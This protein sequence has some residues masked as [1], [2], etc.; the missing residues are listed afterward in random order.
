MELYSGNSVS[1]DYV[2]M[3]T[4]SLF[5]IENTYPLKT[6]WA[7]DYIKILDHSINVKEK[8]GTITVEYKFDGKDP[9]P[10]LIIFSN[11]NNFP[12][13]D[14]RIF[15]DHEDNTICYLVAYFFRHF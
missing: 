13:K 4:T 12:L 5:Q 7:G 15:F 3:K 8:T 10:I 11:T 9:L 6:D 1:Y 2:N 14:T